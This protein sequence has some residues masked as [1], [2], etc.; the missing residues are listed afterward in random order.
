MAHV[1]ITASMGKV[2]VI[3]DGADI[4][5]SV[6]AEGF[7]VTLDDLGRQPALVHLTLMPKSLELDLPDALLDALR[8]DGEEVA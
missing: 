8:F 2:K 4:T 5:G 7:G 3:V 1:Q 6:L